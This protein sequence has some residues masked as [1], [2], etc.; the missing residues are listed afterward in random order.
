MSKLAY[1]THPIYQKHNTGSYHPESANRLAAIDS[2]LEKTGILK[3]IEILQPEPAMEAII[4]NS[5]AKSYIQNVKA[6]IEN[7]EK[8]LDHG[9]TGVCEFSFAAAEH[10]VGAVIKGIDLLKSNDFDKVFCAVRPPGHHAEYD[11]AMGFCIFNNVAIAARYAQQ[12]GSADNV[13]I[14]D[15]D[16]HHGNGTQHI[17]ERDDSIF[18]YSLHQ[19]PFYPG[20]GSQMEV[21]L[22]IGTGFTL[23]RPMKSGSTDTDYLSALETDLNNI[24]KNFKPDLI[25]ISAG[26]DAHKDD[27]LA[28]ILLTE[29]G[30][31]QMSELIA[32]LAWKCCNGKILSVLEGGYNL[33]ALALSVEAH[34]EVLLK[35]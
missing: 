10:A 21:G 11:Q 30:F 23:N 24:Q 8:V 27:P 7:G 28:G 13:L 32:K 29:N 18:Y 26:F 12:I 33:N 17:F 1:I 5:H 4:S 16:V 31:L 20:T 34:L 6:A 9:D 35:H 22:D 2:H 25:L 3:K 14:I 19:F 15:W